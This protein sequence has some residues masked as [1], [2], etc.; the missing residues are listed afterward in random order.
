MEK[1]RL[2]ANVEGSVSRLTSLKKKQMKLQVCNVLV[3]LSK[4]M[5]LP[6]RTNK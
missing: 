1:L 2:R 6:K 5:E 3:T 4:V